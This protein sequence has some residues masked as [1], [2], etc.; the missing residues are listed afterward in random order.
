ML[1]FPE[2]DLMHVMN[3]FTGCAIFQRT[4]IRAIGMALRMIV[5]CLSS[6]AQYLSHRVLKAVYLLERKA[7]R[8]CSASYS[9]CVCPCR[10]KS[11]STCFSQN[12]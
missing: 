12:P 8:N 10:A 1:A 3:K 5:F 6:A 2:N 11:P 9:G 4:V 7:L